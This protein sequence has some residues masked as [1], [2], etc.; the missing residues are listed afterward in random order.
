MITNEL[1][2]PQPFVDAA[3]SDYAYKPKRYS[4]T[5]LLKGTREAILQR[6]HQHEV[7]EDVADRVW[8]IFGSAVHR[9]LQDGQ[10]TESQM[11]E[12]RLTA[13]VPNGYTLS[14]IFDLYD[15]STGTVTDY[16]TASVWKVNFG[17]FDDWRRQL[18]MYVWLLRENGYD[19]KRGEIVALLRDHSNS[20]AKRGEHPRHPVFR[21][22]WDFGDGDISG[23]G[24]WIAAK[25]AEIEAAED[26][27]DGL[28]PLCT[29]EE[30]WHRGE[31][32]AVKK[33]GNKKAHKLFRA[34][35]YPSAEMAFSEAVLYA[36][37]MGGRY[38]V[39][40]RPGTD[41]KCEEYCAA[42]EFCAHYKAIQ[43]GRD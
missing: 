35:S 14:G 38:E 31:C 24:E 13:E 26:L 5:S 25:F 42:R 21:I 19:A 17:D 33:K 4:V 30:R 11:Q 12:C 1:G 18:L 2:L 32:W 22:G 3:T 20:K 37:A 6:R 23:V 29:P 34:E 16:K 7:T 27:P 9:I 8:A 36:D 10:A 40:H 43:A 41:A 28:L 39:E 15:D